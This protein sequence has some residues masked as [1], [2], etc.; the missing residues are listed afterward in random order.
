M[1]DETSEEPRHDAPETGSEP[2]EDEELEGMMSSIRKAERRQRVRAALYG[3]AVV[4]LA[5]VAVYAFFTY[6][7]ELFVP[8]IDMDEAGQEA[9]EKTNDPQCRTLIEQVTA[10]GK[11]FYEYES[12][13]EAHLLG[14]DPDKIREIKRRMESFKARLNK[15]EKLS[16][17]AELRYDDSARQL[18]EWFDYVDMEIGFV[19]RLADERLA[20]LEREQA[21]EASG[22]AGTSADSGIV[23]YSP[24]AAELEQKRDKPKQ[25][26]EERRDGALIALHDAFQ[27]FRVWHSANAHPCGAAAEGEEPWRPEKGAGAEK[28]APSAPAE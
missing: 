11:D 9:W 22:D 15:A 18:D 20:Y 7:D 1:S 16:D 13:V 28:A 14:D 3:L 8:K 4:V 2:E 10:I 24:D 25:S 5:V 6:R 27:N 19:E 26:P 12:F 17:E 23:V 21:R